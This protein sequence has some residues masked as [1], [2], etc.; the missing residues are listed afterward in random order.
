MYFKG[1]GKL[2]TVSPLVVQDPLILSLNL[3]KSRGRKVVCF[4]FSGMCRK[5]FQNLE[6]SF[7]EEQPSLEA[8]FNN[9]HKYS[10]KEL[11]NKSLQL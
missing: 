3:C 10:N 11:F 2:Y 7:N 8:I 1:E 4:R 9:V 5:V 6:D